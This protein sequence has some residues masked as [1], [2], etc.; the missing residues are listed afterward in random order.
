MS[1]IIFTSDETSLS[2]EK[3]KQTTFS[4]FGKSEWNEIETALDPLTNLVL[5]ELCKL[6]GSTKSFENKHQI[7]FCGNIYDTHIRKKLVDLGVL[8]PIE[9]N[10]FS[11]KKNRKKKK[12]TK[13][14]KDDIRQQNTISTINKILDST[15]ATFKSNNFNEAFGFNSSYAEIK[16]ITIIYCAYNLMQKSKVNL[17]KCYELIL[18]IKKTLTIIKELDGLSPTIYA[19]LSETYNRLLEYCNFNYAVMF[20]RFPRLC[21]TTCY[22]KVFPTMAIK[23]Y[24]SQVQLMKEIKS[25]K[26]GLYC[27]KAM[28]GTGKTSFIIALCEHVNTL[29]NLQKARGGVPSTQLIFACSVQPV[30]H[31]VCRMAYNKQI[32]FGMAV[33]EN[34]RVRIINNYSCK[35][36]SDRILIVSD[37]DTTIELLNKN[38]DYILF[39]DEPTV[40]AD[41]ENHP[42]TNAVAKVL[43]LAPENTILCSATLPEIEEIPEPIAFFKEKHNNP[44]II[45]I[46]SKEALIGCEIINFDGSTIAPHN[47]CKTVSELTSVIKNLKDKPFIDR[48]YTA[49]V[50]YRLRQRVLEYFPNDGV[51]DLEKYFADVSNLCQSNIQKAAIELLEFVITKNDDQV[52]EKICIPLGKITIQDEEDEDEQI[53]EEDIIWEKKETNKKE[54]NEDPQYD[55]NKIFTT[56]AYR[57][58]GGCLVTVNDPLHFAQELSKELLE[59]TESASKIISRFKTDSEKLEMCILKLK[60]I[61]NDDERIQKEQQIREDNAPKINFPSH[62]R[63][64]TVRHLLKFAP[65]M[66]DV[67]R[68]SLLQSN[69]NL[70]SLP[71]DLVVPDWVMLLLFT[72]VGIYA[73]NNNQLSSDYT[74][75]VLN[76]AADRKLAFLISDESI[77]YGANYPLSHVVITDEFAENHS[78]GTIFQLAG[79]AGRVGQSW[80]AYAHVGD[81][82]SE[83]IM[84]YIKGID[85]NN[86]VSKE[87]ENFNIAFKRVIEDIQKR[88]PLSKSIYNPDNRKIE[89]IKLSEV[90]PIEKEIKKSFEPKSYYKKK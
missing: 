83:R 54:I 6:G 23:P 66:K 45:S 4:K 85:E 19:D 14:N 30:R 32:P 81:K 61:K 44:E 1:G 82:T 70:D 38:N 12:N 3:T 59:G 62:L 71:L 25:H 57:Y 22:D 31:Q 52:V 53:D 9:Y 34:D 80:V 89:I 90:Q 13:L 55:L 49:P 69:F 60:N 77:C 17:E 27:Y 28:I 68:I 39:I 46:C 76:M 79:R 78:I 75:L 10:V 47:N 8:K 86:G 41:M 20:D 29:R 7:K 36:D 33:T 51:L 87:A 56:Q 48:L 67:I 65:Q 63:I 42:I 84:N 5:D 58:M 64:N 74:K 21:I 24:Q 43:A 26:S 15:I 35:K 18:G 40:G 50:V 72:G 73:P 88:K 16:L 37:L 11:E 2:G